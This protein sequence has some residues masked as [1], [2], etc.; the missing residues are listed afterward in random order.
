MYIVFVILQTDDGGPTAK[1]S[2]RLTLVQGEYPTNVVEPVSYALA[3]RRGGGGEFDGALHLTN[4]RLVLQRTGS[5]K[6]LYY[7][8][9]GHGF[10]AAV[11]ADVLLLYIN[12]LVRH[13]DW[14]K[15]IWLQDCLGVE[16]PVDAPP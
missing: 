14:C 11:I 12:H 16:S 8:R 13:D 4:F 9:P 10:A 7:I 6:V 5:G 15:R 2:S 1:V 3:R